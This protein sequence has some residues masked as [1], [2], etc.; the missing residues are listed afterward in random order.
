MNCIA[1]R[2]ELTATAGA[3]FCAGHMSAPA[4]KRGGWLS[5]YRRAQRRGSGTVIDASNIA[6]RLW[7]GSAPPSDRDLPNFDV[8]VLCALEYQPITMA[9]H[10]PVVRC[11]ITDDIPS[12]RELEQAVGAARQTASALVAGK[13]V[14]VTCAQGRNRS[15]L[16]TGLALGLVTRMRGKTIVDL[17]RT[18]RPSA[19]TN[20]HFVRVLERLIRP[21]VE[22]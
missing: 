2:C 15:G 4:G 14:L 3:V 21:S 11:P 5:A 16:V 6:K 18:R 20:P 8:V 9:F 10:G 22:T 13:T 17:I 12:P 1:P 7:M 19:L